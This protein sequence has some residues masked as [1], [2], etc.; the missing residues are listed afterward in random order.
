MDMP[1]GR[2]RLVLYAYLGISVFIC[3]PLT[4]VYAAAAVVDYGL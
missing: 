2:E 3:L 4:W 1:R